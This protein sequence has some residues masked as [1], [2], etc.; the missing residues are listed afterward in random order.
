MTS[1][2]SVKTQSRQ[3]KLK[4]FGMIAALATF[5]VLLLGWIVWRE[6]RVMRGELLRSALLAVQA[7]DVKQIESLPFKSNDRDLAGFKQAGMQLRR[8]VS[9][10]QLSW[11]PADGY[12]GI[13]SMKQRDG[14]IVFGPESI[15]EGDRH[16]SPPG[17]VYKQPP[18]ELIKLFASRQSVTVGPFTDEYGTFV[19]AFVPLPNRVNSPSGTVMGFDIMA[20]KWFL[21]VMKRVA[22]P[23]VGM[24]L[25]LFAVSALLITRH[26]RGGIKSAL[27]Q[28]GRSRIW[29]FTGGALLMALGLGGWIMYQAD[30]DM[31]GELL[32]KTRLVAQALDIDRIQTLSGTKSDLANVGY[33]RLKQQLAMIRSAT[34][35]CRFTY[36]IGRK[37]N[38][39]MF[40][41]VD[42]ESVGSSDYSPPG[43]PFDEPSAEFK[44]IFDTRIAITEGPVADRWGTWIS[45][46]FPLTDPR[47]GVVVAVMGMDIDAH[48][49]GWDVTAKV[50]LPLALMFVL[51]IGVISTLFAMRRVPD[52]PKPV[53]HRM[54]PVLTVLLLVLVGGF[55]WVLINMQ[56]ARVKEISRMVEQEASGDFDQ[57]LEEHTRALVAVQETIIRDADLLSALK[58]GDRDRLLVAYRPLLDHLKTRYGVTH[59]YFSDTNR[60]CLLRVHQPTRYGDRLDRFTAREAERKGEISSGLELGPLGTLTLRVVRPVF[61][62][63]KLVGY[64]ELGK[65]LEEFLKYITNVEG[66][67]RVALISKNMLD[68]AQWEEGMR[69]LGREPSWDHLPDHVINYSSMSSSKDSNRLIEAAVN[70]VNKHADEIK[71]DNNNWRL[72]LRPMNDAAGQKVGDFLL[73]DDVTE[74][75]ASQYRLLT[76]TIAGVGVVLAAVLGF[77]FVLLRRADVS[78]LAQQAELR[79]SKVRFEQ[80]AEQA[81]T[82]TWEVDA[83]GLYTF[84]SPVVEQ[85]LGYRAEDLVGKK[86]FY[87]LHPENMREAFKTAALEVFARKQPFL[88]FINRIQS[89]TGA[90]L[91]ISTNGIPRLDKHGDLIGYRGNDTDITE[92]KQIEEA[93]SQS[94]ALQRILLDNIDA[95]VVVIDPT[96]HRIERSNVKAG[97]M[98]GAGADQIIGCVCHKFLCPAEKGRCPVTDLGLSIDNCERTLLRADGS[99]M[100]VMKSIRRIQIDGHEKLLETFIDITQLKQAEMER[101]LQIQMQKILINLSSSFINLPLEQVDAAIYKSLGELGSFV[102]ADRAYVF[103]YMDEQQTCRNTHEWCAEGIEPQK[104]DLQSV[105]LTIMPDWLGTHRQ[106]KTIRI[107]DILALQPEDHTR[108]ILEAQG[109]KSLL[110]VPLMSGEFCIGFVGFDAVRTIHAYTEAEKQLLLVFAQML[111]N[112]RLRHTNEQA[113]TISRQQAE[114]ANVAK[115]DFLANMSHEIRTP[116]NGVIGMTS[117]LLDS[118]LNN[119]QREFAKI[120]MSSANNL[121][122][123]LNDILDISKIESGKLQLE[124]LNFGLRNVLEE[125]I[126][127]LALRAQQKGVE[128]VCA[129]APDVPNCLIGDPIRLRQVLVNLAGNAV[130]FTERGE[131]VLRVEI[132]AKKRS[133]TSDRPDRPEHLVAVPSECLCLR[134]T[135]RDTGIGIAKNAFDKLFK[136]FSQGDASTT[137]RFGGTGLGLTI[138][139]Q[140]SEMMGGEIGVESEEGKGTIFWFTACFN[141]GTAECTE[142]PVAAVPLV[143]IRGTSILVVDDNETNRQVLT[144]QLHAWGVRAR[145]ASDGPQALEILRQAQRGG[146]CFHAALLDMQMPGMDGIALAKVIRNEPAHAGMRLVLLTS[147]D[148]PGGTAQVK[149]AGFSAWLTKP[150]RPSELYNIL[151]DILAGQSLWSASESPATECVPAEDIASNPAFSA[152]A[153]LV[154]DNPVN[155]LV[156]KKYLVKLGL[157]VDAV[158]NGFAA[159]EALAHFTYDLVFM[160]VQMEGMDGYETTRRIRS[161]TDKRFNPSIPIIAM[162]AHAMQSD[163]EKCLAA[164]MDDYVSKPIEFTILEQTV[165]KWLQKK[166]GL[167]E[168]VQVPR[169]DSSAHDI[170]NRASLAER[171]M[172]DAAMVRQITSAFLN[173][174]PRRL[175]ALQACLSKGDLTGVEYQAHTIKGSSANVGGE[176]MAV[177]ASDMEMAGKA[178]DIEML[179]TCLGDLCAAFQRVK[180]AMQGGDQDVG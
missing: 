88:N 70:A 86:Y 128:F 175:D 112:I 104:D 96:T 68:R 84:V 150:V 16:A 32:Q 159:L 135:V 131:I 24:L 82:I 36:L 15:P 9:T 171:M 142:A 44:E 80:L 100:A 109:I 20:D 19:S 22:L 177:I 57:L 14:V 17:S 151:S 165:D 102:G 95:G 7:M 154:E 146:I 83:K 121:L 35:R 91:W 108:Q 65:E 92:R 85:V 136:K 127:P 138:A 47:T 31:R 5:V 137:R 38:G 170:W 144:A 72:I 21:T 93:L 48:D 124:E 23:S 13:Y 58:A 3:K 67:Q 113:L 149:E 129:V 4:M 74:F 99:S 55:V 8:L 61:D 45:A 123:L 107:P 98:F 145:V 143:D 11:V 115:S 156:A 2:L 64:L 97:E 51:M 158:E 42:S 62:S 27:K 12:I 75:K 168:E 54:F 119:E 53:L 111:V 49:W 139:K 41:Y 103:D 73:L 105:P 106:G 101:E 63:D 6:D 167:I 120:A 52:S 147:L 76:V 174:I 59:F 140:L 90:I 10:F 89:K 160:D 18:P 163:R 178:G 28:D 29:T 116:L 118:R 46:L 30:R 33:Q 179:K 66:V 126:A 173:D 157:T 125:V 26:M 117:L 110:T 122:T 71:V 164:G 40:F 161:S 77:I 169:V 130:K 152:R 39:A 79:E 166:T 69:L 81:R 114:A 1:D 132:N 153:L 78:L 172:G 94:D 34:P 25:A 176:S 141:S 162:T 134:F 43:Q 60:V 133:G 155:T 87:D 50:A 180:Q 56:Q 148:H 37:P